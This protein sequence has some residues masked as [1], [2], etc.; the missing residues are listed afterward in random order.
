MKGNVMEM[1]ERRIT[2]A[3]TTFLPRNEPNAA[4]LGDWFKSRFGVDAVVTDL[5]NRT[6]RTRSTAW[7]SRR[8]RRTWTASGAG[9]SEARRRSARWRAAT[10]PSTAS[11]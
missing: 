1:V 7:W 6:R 11:S 10:C 2:S 8:R 5:E 4:G 3:V 9:L